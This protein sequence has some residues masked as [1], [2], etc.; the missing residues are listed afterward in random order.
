[1]NAIPNDPN[2]PRTQGTDNRWLLA[3]VC[4]CAVVLSGFAVYSYK[5][6]NSMQQVA[7]ANGTAASQQT[8][9]PQKVPSA[10]DVNVPRKRGS[11]N[12]PMPG[13]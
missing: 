7:A 2:T 3:A 5:L 10:Q 9:A 4:V 1:M 6:T 11:Q 13:G 8:A 12:T